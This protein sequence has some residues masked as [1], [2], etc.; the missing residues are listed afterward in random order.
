MR[1]GDRRLAWRH[2]LET[3]LKIV[4]ELGVF[5]GTP[6]WR[7]DD[8]VQWPATFRNRR[9]RCRWYLQTGKGTRRDVHITSDN[10]GCSYSSRYQTAFRAGQLSG[11]PLAWNRVPERT[12]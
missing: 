4:S 6:A 12:S 1:G 5:G 10:G 9:C 8:L 3:A 7:M 2:S 11:D